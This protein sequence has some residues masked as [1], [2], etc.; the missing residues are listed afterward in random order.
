LRDSLRGFLSNALT[1]VGEP[2]ALERAW[3]SCALTRSMIESRREVRF[4]DERSGFG[5]LPLLGEVLK[6]SLVR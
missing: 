5:T 3:F 4:V 2:S 1:V 6:E